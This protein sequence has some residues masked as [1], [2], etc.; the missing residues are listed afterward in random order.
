LRA[1]PSCAKLAWEGNGGRRRA[2]THLVSAGSMRI[3]HVFR[4]PVGGLF[5]HVRDLARG[6][7]SFGHSVGV[8]CDSTTGGEA[9]EKA[10]KGI[11]Q[12]CALG[13]Q[14][15][16]ISR[17]PGL[18]DV[19]GARAVAAAAREMKPDILHGHGAKGGLYARLAGK[20]L[21]IPSVYTPH[22]GSL[23]Y[24]WS[25]PQ[26]AVFLSAERA[27]R[28]IGTGLLF[29]CEFERRRFDEKIGIGGTPSKVVYNGLWPDELQ[30]VTPVADA[31]D[32]IYLGDLRMLKGTDVLIEALTAFNGHRPATA[33]I[34]GDGENREEFEELARMRGLNG[35]VR[36]LGPMPARQAFGMG[37][38][39]VMPSRAE[40]FPYVI[41]EAAAAGMPIIATA[42]GGIP[43]VLPAE[44]LV[45]P[46]RPRELAEAITALIDDP[47]RRERHGAM[48]RELVR[49]RFSAERM[50]AEI[51]EFYRVLTG[52]GTAG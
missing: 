10:L 4:T 18:G 42:V 36:F 45:Q 16:P 35:H 7:S 13:I 39:L 25:T 51:T 14:R 5:R 17:L 11:E 29:V 31:S 47:V 6:Q 9:A 32:V 52:N 23:H 1:A 30:P 8:V 49:S 41:L 19:G 22:G 46:D 33:V 2:A 26:G 34:A 37:N 20:M 27:L 48:M 38:I 44:A 12:L 21:G 28:R 15:R 40:S 3:L 43:E 50:C 24:S